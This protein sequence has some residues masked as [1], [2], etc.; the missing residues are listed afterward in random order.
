MDFSEKLS[1]LRREK[2]L[3]QRAV[4]ADLNIS[5][6]LLSHYEKGIREPGLQFVA[7]ACRYFDVSA[8]YLLGLCDSRE[9][10]SLGAEVA[11]LF[12]RLSENRASEMREIIK[13]L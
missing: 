9:C 6:A 5:Q 13:D 11:K 4:A 8:D 2:G 12:S 7:R 3:S 1:A 10:A